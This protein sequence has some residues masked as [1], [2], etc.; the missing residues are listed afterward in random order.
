LYH[1]LT[2]QIMPQENKNR[3]GAFSVLEECI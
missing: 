3:N 2:C 1:V